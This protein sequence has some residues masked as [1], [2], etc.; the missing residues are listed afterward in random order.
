MQYLN[1]MDIKKNDKSSVDP[2]KV[3]HVDI[4]VLIL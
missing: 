1:S 2:L 4:F 3:G